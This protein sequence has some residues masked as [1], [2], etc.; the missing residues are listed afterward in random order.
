[1]TIS[2]VEFK[3]KVGRD[4]ADASACSQSG[5]GSNVGQLMS[6]G[7]LSY[8]R[9]PKRPPEFLLSAALVSV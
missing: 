4:S 8:S 1:M 7:T 9:V 5:E 6:R 2:I 3:D